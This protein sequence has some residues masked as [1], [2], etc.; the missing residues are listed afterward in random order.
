MVEIQDSAHTVA[1]G[2]TKVSRPDPER[3]I[4]IA[5]KLNPAESVAEAA[6]RCGSTFPL[7]RSVLPAVPLGSTETAVSAMVEHLHGC[8][9][10]V[11]EASARMRLVVAEGPI[12]SVPCAFHVELMSFA[13]S[14]G[15][16]EHLSNDRNISLPESLKDKVAVIAGLDTRVLA[17]RP[18]A[19]EPVGDGSPGLPIADVI[20]AYNFREEPESTN[21]LPPWCW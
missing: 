17:Q 20:R 11:V 2:F 16:D 14:D 13:R 6:D 18:N 1:Q 5:V 7:D 15:S 9:F 19:V 3:R 8:G 21:A 4:R 12:S 10:S